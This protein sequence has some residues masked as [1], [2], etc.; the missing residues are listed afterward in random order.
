MYLRL[1][2]NTKQYY[3]EVR[4]DFLTCMPRPRLM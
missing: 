2:Y 1:Y 4:T 3:D